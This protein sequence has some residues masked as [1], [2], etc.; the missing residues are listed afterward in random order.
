MC[1][2]RYVQPPSVRNAT[3]LAHHAQQ[4]LEELLEHERPPSS[5]DV[6][7]FC[8]T[9]LGIPARDAGVEQARY[10]CRDCYS[11]PDLCSRCILTVHKFSPFHRLLRWDQ[12]QLFWQR[13]STSELGMR[14]Y[15]G[16]GGRP[17]P[18]I[19]RRPRMMVIVHEHGVG[20]Y[21]VSL[22][23]CLQQPDSD[24]TLR[25]P[26]P[27]QLLRLGLYPAS[28]TTPR[29]AFS[30]NLM[31]SYHLLSLQANVT[32]QDF[33]T[34]LT[35]TADNVRPST[36]PDRYREFMASMRE[37]AFLRACKRAGR[38]PS[39]KMPARS[40]AVLCPACPQPGINMR[41][42]WQS[43]DPNTSYLDALFYAID[44]NYHQHQRKKPTD[45]ND[46][47]FTKNAAYFANE[48]DY[49][50]YVDLMGDVPAEESTCNKFGAIGPGGYTH[51]VSGILA[52][53]CRHELFLPQ[54]IIDLISNEKAHLVDFAVVSGTQP[55]VELTL[56]KQYYDVSCQYMVRLPLRLKEMAKIVP[57]LESIKTVKLPTIHGAIPAF[58][59]YAH[60]EQCQSFQSPNCLPGSAKYDG[61]TNERK[62]GQTNP[63]A[64]RAKEMLSG[65][66]HD[67]INDIISDL[68]VRNV[69]AMAQ[70]LV[71]KHEEA[72]KY[73]AQAK[74]YLD[75]VE[76]S[77]PAEILEQWKQEE[78]EWLAKVVDIRNHK[79]LDNPFVAPQDAM[80]K[81]ATSR[82]LKRAD[83]GLPGEGWS[84]E[85]VAAIEG[86]VDLETEKNEL[87]DKIYS[88]DSTKARQCSAI[89]AKVS[90]F[91]AKAETCE[92]IYSR[93]V[94]PLVSQAYNA[95]AAEIA[96][97]PSALPWRDAADDLSHQI[98][99]RTS[100]RRPV[101]RDAF[102]SSLIA[103]VQA[104]EIYLPSLYHSLIRR[105]PAMA[106]PVA[107]ERKLREGQARD[108]LNEVRL[109]ITAR[110]SLQNLEDQGAG[111]AHGKRIREMDE[112]H[113]AAA[114]KARE[115]YQRL[116]DILLVLG[117]KPDNPTFRELTDSD[118]RAISESRRRGES[119]ETRSWLWADLSILRKQNMASGVKEFMIK[120]SRP[121]WFQCRAAKA[122]WEE[123]E[124][125][126]REEM[127]R[128]LMYFARQVAEWTAHAQ[129]AIQEGRMGAAAYARR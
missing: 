88:T 97:V 39:A 119:R 63:A 56:W 73:L 27:I 40:L 80:S 114:D 35:R 11:Q 58:H 85:L 42:G 6:C 84:V 31:N 93:Y 22:C 66:R 51:P 16:H 129:I 50:K 68:N 52:L 89:A 105:H 90:A 5:Q 32:A 61:E 83:A 19:S 49:R 115:E 75:Q 64:L 26:E 122:R 55:Y 94:N 99:T 15:A 79:T 70:T 14:L 128:T 7:A 4:A 82:S 108:T 81:A 78:A 102:L 13:A 59:Q 28:W 65:G 101:L 23:E 103:E 67:F 110:Y 124:H 29:T 71:D 60:R 37:Y 33:Y 12:R 44:G 72:V 1:R 9:Q 125:L 30:L 91:V 120:H 116:R 98:P 46:F 10:R 86:M 8:D 69:H 109:Q 41:S 20:H 117:L 104:V 38:R 53:S 127:F 106:S 96:V 21:P 107:I 112:T 2:H 3:F 36:V 87:L 121:H 17:C 24:T 57:A 43:R 126:T 47:P 48:D 34:Y 113:Q 123:E 54:S 118:C 45:P 18:L 95:V 92:D 77:I 100:R 62:W 25:T 76:M 74:D 111:Q